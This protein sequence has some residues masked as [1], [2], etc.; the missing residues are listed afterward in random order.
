MKQ[1]YHTNNM[2]E[3]KGIDES[4]SPKSQDILR[5]NLERLSLNDLPKI[6]PDYKGKNGTLNTLA[7][8]DQLSLE[9]IK[10]LVPC[11]S[12]IVSLAFQSVGFILQQNKNGFVGAD[13]Y[14]YYPAFREPGALKV[15]Q[16][17]GL[18]IAT[19][20]LMN[21]MESDLMVTQSYFNLNKISTKYHDPK[22]NI[23]LLDDQRSPLTTQLLIRKAEKASRCLYVHHKDNPRDRRAFGI[24]LLA[25]PHN[26]HGWDTYDRADP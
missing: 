25:A 12:S 4:P 10:Q 23:L 13:L 14:G 15:V 26:R 16:E 17:T 20:D 8:P 21:A 1:V 11:V 5:G 7:K 2:M 24:V 6:P 22:D 19:V 18:E 3:Q 9:L